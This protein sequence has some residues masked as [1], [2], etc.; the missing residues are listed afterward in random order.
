MLTG[1]MGA[2]PG[3]P[4]CNEVRSDTL[5]QVSRQSLVNSRQDAAVYDTKALL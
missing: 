3:S 1:D 4:V 2:E 5:L